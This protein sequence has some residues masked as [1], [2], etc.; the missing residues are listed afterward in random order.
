MNRKTPTMN[1]QTLT[2]NPALNAAKLDI[3]ARIRATL[4]PR[5]LP[6]KRLDIY[7]THM[8]QNEL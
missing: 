8:T 7:L 1:D 3:V 5:G 6:G 4:G 2:Q